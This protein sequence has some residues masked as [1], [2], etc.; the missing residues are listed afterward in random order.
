M[1]GA[2]VKRCVSGSRTLPVINHLFLPAMRKTIYVSLNADGVSYRQ[3]MNIPPPVVVSEGNISRLSDADSGVLITALN[4]KCSQTSYMVLFG[5]T[6]CCLTLFCLLVSA[7]WNPYLWYELCACL[8]FIPLVRWLGQVDRKRFEIELRYNMDER[9]AQVYQQFNNHFL[10]FSRS[11]RIWQ[12]L[13]VSKGIKRV[14]LKSVSI[15]KVPIPYFITNVDIPCISLRNMMLF[16]LPERLLIK[17]G[18]TF[19]VVFYKNLQVTTSVTRF[20]ESDVLPRDADVVDFT[21]KFNNSGRLPICLYSQYTFKSDTG[22]NEVIVSSK[23][24]AMDA[25]A[26][27]LTKIGELQTKIKEYAN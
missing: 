7:F 6:P 22:I 26:S 13:K 24:M 15:N 5:I 25:C 9:H 4:E 16:F 1:P 20:I 12:Y 27:F 19:E 10:K 3:K 17:R 18:N 23:Y 8:L 2:A 11:S 14:S 21:W